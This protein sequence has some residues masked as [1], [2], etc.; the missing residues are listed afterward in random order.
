MKLPKRLGCLEEHRDLPP[1]VSG[2]KAQQKSDCFIA[3]TK[4]NRRAT[5]CTAP[6]QCTPLHGQEKLRKN[7]LVLLLDLSII[8]ESFTRTITSYSR[9]S[10]HRRLDVGRAGTRDTWAELNRDVPLK[11]GRVASWQPY[12]IYPEY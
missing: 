8:P 1:V 7:V 2:V 9:K 10:G 4:F 12:D 6:V 5:G 11:P 3:K